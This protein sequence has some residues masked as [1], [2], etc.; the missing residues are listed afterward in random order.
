M[1]DIYNHQVA[2]GV[3]SEYERV[4]S[5]MTEEHNGGAQVE[6][7]DLCIAH[8]CNWEPYSLCYYT[9]SMR[10]TH[11]NPSHRWYY[12]KTIQGGYTSWNPHRILSMKRVMARPDYHVHEAIAER[13]SWVLPASGRFSLANA[14]AWI[15]EY[16]TS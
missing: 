9:G 8:Y 13:D 3:Y 14:E 10:D 15:H 6:M 5:F 12:F 1:L 11:Y 4:P 7:G 2:E 16:L